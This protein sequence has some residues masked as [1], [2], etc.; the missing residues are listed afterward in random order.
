MI[1][2]KLTALLAEHIE[3][4]PATLTMETTFES[5]GIDSL[6]TVE[7]LM[8]LEEELGCELELDEP[9]ATVGDLVAFIEKKMGTSK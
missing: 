8:K 4:D 6:D 7:V 3:A 9:V 1:Y 5:L 2:E